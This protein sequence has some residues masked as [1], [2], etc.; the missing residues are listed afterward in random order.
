M[1][2]TAD[3]RAHRSRSLFVFLA[4]ALGLGACGSDYSPP[5]EDESCPPGQHVGPDGCVANA[6]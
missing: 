1:T 3:N 2:R 6:E 5:N 4:M